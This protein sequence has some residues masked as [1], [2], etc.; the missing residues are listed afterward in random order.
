MARGN[1]FQD[2]RSE[3]E[4][5]RCT[6]NSHVSCPLRGKFLKFSGLSDQVVKMYR[7][8]EEKDLTKE[9]SAHVPLK[10]QRAQSIP[11]S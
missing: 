2:K 8:E 3:H 11:G 9:I 1:E 5:R 10:L 4:R 6:K 7:I